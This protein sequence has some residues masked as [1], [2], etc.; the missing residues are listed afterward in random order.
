MDDVKFVLTR[1]R[2]KEESQVLSVRIPKDMLRDLDAVA[3]KTNR[4]RNEIMTK[5]IEFML[6]HLEIAE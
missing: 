2:Y 3:Q 4:T 5:A 6:E 1:K